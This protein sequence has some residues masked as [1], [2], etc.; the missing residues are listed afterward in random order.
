M[1]V[2]P[3][4]IGQDNNKGIIC[5]RLILLIFGRLPAPALFKTLTCQKSYSFSELI[6]NFVMAISWSKLTAMPAPIKIMIM[7]FDYQVVTVFPSLMLQIRFIGYL[8][9]L[10]VANQ[11]PIQ[12]PKEEHSKETN[13][14]SSDWSIPTSP[15]SESSVPNEQSSTGIHHSHISNWSRSIRSQRPDCTRLIGSRMCTSRGSNVKSIIS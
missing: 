10:Q 13:H 1:L 4:L 5:Y 3:K 14:Y 8:I 9:R 2:H 6:F 11:Y 12:Q 15:I 7:I